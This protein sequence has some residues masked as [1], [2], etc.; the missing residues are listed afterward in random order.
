VTVCCPDC[1][2]PVQV[3]V[4]SKEGRCAECRPQRQHSVKR[5][6]NAQERW[7]QLLDEHGGSA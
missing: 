6:P 7:R 3:R 4:S 5:E 1:F 2:Q